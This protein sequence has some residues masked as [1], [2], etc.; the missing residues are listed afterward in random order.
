MGWGFYGRARELQALREI[1]K[2]K[3]WFFA[4]I[5]GRRRIGKTTLVL[6]ALSGALRERW[7][8]A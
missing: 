8:P 5:S 4:R 2:R 6:Q 1:L 3:R 7:P